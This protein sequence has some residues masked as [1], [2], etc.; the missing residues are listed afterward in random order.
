MA[1]SKKK[2]AVP[3]V[4]GLMG[5]IVTRKLKNSY[6]I[7]MRTQELLKFMISAKNWETAQELMELIRTN[8]K[9]V[10]KTLPHQIVAINVMRHFLK[11]IREEYDS[12]L[13]RKGEDTTLHHMITELNSGPA[14]DYSKKLPS[15]KDDL[16]L[17]ASEYRA[18]LESSSA[19]VSSRAVDQIFATEVI[20]TYGKS[21]LVEQFLKAAAKEK[22]MHVVVVESSQV[23]G[24]HT[25]AANLAK[26]PNIRVSLI[27]DT[28]V[29]DLMTRTNKV[30]IG[31]H[32][33]YADGGLQTIAGVHNVAAT[34]KYFSVP[35][36]VLTHMYKL[37]PK[38]TVS[39]EEYQSARNAGSRKL[40]ET[41][42][43]SKF[44]IVDPIFDYVPPELIQLF[45]IAH[46]NG[47]SPSYIHRLLMEV[48]HKDDY[49]I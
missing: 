20:L 41:C 26:V 3:T 40:W 28:N 29:F 44:N 17:R 34:A 21:N 30:I 25:M 32:L 33:V 36:I 12:G 43:T 16:L 14:T 11:I 46:Q 4:E 45:I 31:T 22:P 24:G 1:E 10:E 39:C 23:L 49:Y 42:N 8:I 15:L 6:D 2:V 48:Y 7:A 47:Y 38:F 9:L 5:D 37:T 19:N 18:E 35:V 27:P 13:K